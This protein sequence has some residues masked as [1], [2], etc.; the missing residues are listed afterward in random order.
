VLGDNA[1]LRAATATLAAVALLLGFV[2]WQSFEAML[3]GHDE[4]ARTPQLA[5][6]RA[7]SRLLGNTPEVARTSYI[8]PEVLTA[9]DHGRDIA[10]AVTA[11]AERTADDRLALVWRDPGVQE[12]T[13]KLLR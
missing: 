8:H 1:G 5:A 4:T 9:F 13:L 6:I 11:A 2:I 12:A 7:T 10:A 3:R